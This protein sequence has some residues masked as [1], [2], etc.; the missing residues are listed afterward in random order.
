MFE[1]ATTIPQTYQIQFNFHFEVTQR[2]LMLA[3][4]LPADRYYAKRDY[5]HGSIHDTF[6]HLLGADQLWR[7]VITNLPDPEQLP[8]STDIEAV[9]AWLAVER[10]GWHELLAPLDA[11]TLFATFDRETPWGSHAFTMWTTLQ[12]VILHGMQHQSELARLLT[13]VG[14]SPGDTDFLTY[15]DFPTEVDLPV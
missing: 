9:A 7:K 10:Q 5:S 13:E 6:V 2:L 8:E 15:V 12:H 3:Q 11:A 14:H 4:A 1:R